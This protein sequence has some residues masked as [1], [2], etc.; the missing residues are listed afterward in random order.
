MSGQVSVACLGGGED[1][2]R[3]D[4]GKFASRARPQL[5]RGLRSPVARRASRT[6]RWLAPAAAAVLAVVGTIVGV[7]L[8][9]AHGPEPGSGQ[10]TRPQTTAGM[11]RYYVAVVSRIIDD[12]TVTTRAVVH[13]S[14]T[15]VA[16]ASVR[17][18][19]LGNATGPSISAAGD[20]RTFVITETGGH[21][22]YH[23]LAWFFLLRVAANGRSVTLTRLPISVP[24]WLA[25]AGSLLSPDGARLAMQEQSCYRHGCYY[26]GIRVITIATGAARTWTTSAKGAPFAV[27]WG[28]NSTVAF[29]WGSKY[30]LLNVTSGG[31]NLL[32]SRPIASPA[33][34]QYG[35]VPTAL[36]TPDQTKLITST[37][38]NIPDRNGTDTVVAKII[39]MSARTGR[40]LRILSTTTVH[41]AT[42]GGQG[43]AG[44]LDDDCGVLSLA[45]AGT[46]VLVSC[47]TFG[48]VD[49][50][51]FTPLPGFPSGSSSGIGGQDTAAW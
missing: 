15:G 22:P 5:I 20:D 41:G 25:I 9:G 50:N 31:G 29:L 28:G 14:A 10:P 40:L 26:T 12:R 11:P 39:E 48:R 17:V 23:R 6:V 16:L 49:N 37:V 1:R 19:R 21:P 13:D 18:P 36:V 43:S 38:R 4:L 34:Q 44:I 46:N 45:P 47:F 27:S 35:Y 51:S 8:S 3:R 2:L 7:S 24:H 42:R 33:A 32:A 30:R